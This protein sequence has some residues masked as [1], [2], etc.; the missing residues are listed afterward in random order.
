MRGILQMVAEDLVFHLIDYF[1][2]ASAWGDAEIRIFVDRGIGVLKSL[3]T[4][5]S[6]TICPGI[7]R[8]R[9]AISATTPRMRN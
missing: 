5:A 4:F 7:Q 6:S 3:S 9:S 2:Y 8:T 1:V